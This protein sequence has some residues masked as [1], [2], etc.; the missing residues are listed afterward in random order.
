MFQRI[1][2]DLAPL[3]FSIDACMP[4]SG[5]PAPTS[6]PALVSPTM[7]TLP[8]ETHSRECAS[9]FVQ[10]AFSKL[11]WQSSSRQTRGFTPQGSPD[12]VRAFL[13]S[14]RLLQEFG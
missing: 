11:P 5:S 1:G 9:S 12:K 8:F 13:G 7:P 14:N 3:A 4:L 2:T 6:P 10:T